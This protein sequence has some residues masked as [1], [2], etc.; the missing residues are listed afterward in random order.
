MLHTEVG[1]VGTYMYLSACVVGRVS[2]ELGL[3]SKTFWERC[4]SLLNFS[5]SAAFSLEAEET[6]PVS[7]RLT[8]ITINNPTYPLKYTELDQKRFGSKLYVCS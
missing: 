6:A 1:F 8:F 3:L 7:P 5:F 2:G 4:R